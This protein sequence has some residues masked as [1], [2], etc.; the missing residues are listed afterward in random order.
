MKRTCLCCPVQFEPFTRGGKT[1]IFCSTS[2][3]A[4]F[5]KAA[6]I[7]TEKAVAAGLLSVEVV[8]GA[9]RPTYTAPASAP[10]MV[11]EAR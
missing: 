6:R 4:R 8:L 2:C 7:W 3:R 11:D 5:H 10:G 1:K 9:L